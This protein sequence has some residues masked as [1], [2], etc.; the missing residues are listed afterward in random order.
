[1]SRLSLS[2][3]TLTAVTA[4]LAMT[5]SGCAPVGPNYKRPDLA[6][7]PGYRHA[8]ST[9][10]AESMADIPWWQV[11]EDP[12]LQALLRDAI[13]NNLDLRLAVARVQEARALAGVAKSFLYPDINLTA[14]YA[15]NQASRN[16]QPPGALENGDRTYNNTSLAANL[17]W[18]ADLFGRLRRNNEAAFARYL[19]TEEGRRA[20]LVTLVSDVA[21]AYF[22]LQELDLQLTIARNTLGLNE[23][24]VVFYTDRLN[25]GVSNR[26]EVDQARANR[27][28]TAASIPELE[29]QIA[30]LENAVSV[31]AGRAPGA[32][33]RGTTLGDKVLPPVA[34][35]GVPAALL[36]RRP[37]VIQAERELMAAN[38]DVGAAKALFYPR[39]S[40]TGSLGTIS[41][42]LGDFLKGD[43][44]IWSVGAGLF[45]PLFNAGRIKRNHEAAQARFDQAVVV[46]QR[47][48]L[49]AYR[50]VAD[51]LISAQK[52][53]EAR[54][55]L[56]DGVVALR[57]AGELSRLR[58]DQGLSTY[59]EV[60]YADQ[61]LFR[62]ELQLARTRGAQLRV[63][64]QLYR[65]LGG[66]WQ[67]EATTATPASP[68][69]T[70][71]PPPPPPPPAPPVPPAPPG[72]AQ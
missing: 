63:I 15:G 28:I 58:Y 41:G 45:Q 48:A 14:G 55:V 8:A 6:P 56:E 1:M 46:Y 66:G 40:L 19:A 62:Q 43:S 69:G 67:A 27:A 25:G 53:A 31:L 5:V 70:P 32:I 18:E 61:E 24:T 20:V 64:A 26:L 71:P 34:P 11:F 42:D 16:S 72:A 22:L 52:L 57:D 2:P 54:T 10:P 23:R 65:A 44:I 39:I 51:A 60:L 13:A 50:E 9:V 29:R 68:A 21:S 30:V 17:S 49:N 3:R 4:L 37:D 7:P 33:V 38:A 12:Q 47:A 59:L 36:E 35:V